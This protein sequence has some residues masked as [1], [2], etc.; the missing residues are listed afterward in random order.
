MK[1]NVRHG[2]LVTIR[3]IQKSQ[4]KPYIPAKW[5][6]KCDCGNEKIFHECNLYGRGIKSCGCLE[7]KTKRIYD[8]KDYF[9]ILK[10]RIQNSVSIDEKGCW[11]WMGSKH[12]Q[13]YGNIRFKK[14]YGLTHRVTWEIYK[15]EIPTGMKVCHKCDMPSCCNPEH[16][17][18]GS[19][20]DNVNDSQD[21]GR[22]KIGNPP[23]RNKLNY[24]QVQEI[25]SLNE[26]G[27][28]RKQIEK[29]FGISP[30]CV[31]KIL[32]GISWK[33]NWTKDH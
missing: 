17:F 10:E 8:R 28:T 16:L 22:W 7:F 21:K 2:K 18:L 27:M 14:K 25:K 26:E 6:C 29:K 11:L 23:R 4:K 33:I 31:A 15:G 3:K 12:R 32:T 24:E 1:E 19:Q 5:L 13:G 30:T 9:E 20:K